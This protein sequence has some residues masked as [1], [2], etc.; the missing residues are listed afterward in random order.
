MGIIVSHV[1]LNSGAVRNQ[2]IQAHR[3]DAPYQISVVQEL[4]PVPRGRIVTAGSRT[5][6]GSVK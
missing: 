5:E 6:N 2:A 3:Q 4:N 1:D